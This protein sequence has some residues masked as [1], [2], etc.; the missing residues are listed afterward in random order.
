MVAVLAL[1]LGAGAA[2][3]PDPVAPAKLDD[4]CLDAGCAKKALDHFGR[5][6]AQQRGGK[7]DRPLRVSFIGDSL[8]ASDSISNALREKL[9]ALV[10]AGGPGFVFAE[11]PHPFCQHHAVTRFASG[12][13]Q[14]FGV[15][16]SVPP[17]RL[18]GL[19]GSI[20]GSGVVRF[21]PVKP[22]S[23][24]DVHYLEQPSGGAF[25]IVADNTVLETVATAATAKHAAFKRVAVPATTKAIELRAKHHVRLFGATL[26]ASKGAVV[27]NLGVVNATAKGMSKYNL[28][29]HLRNQLAHRAPDLVIVML[30][31]NEAEWL[32]PVGAGMAE[33][34]QVFGELLA[35]VR[36]AN[37]DSSCLVISPLDQIDW[38][39]PNAPA[40]TSVPAMVE[41]QHRAA[42]AHG[43]AF[44]NIYEWMGGKG[45]SMTWFKRGL[46]VKDFQHPT[47]QGANRI[48]DALYS[49]LV[50]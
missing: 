24:I 35:S 15:S 21:A 9:G 1:A 27:D 43:C 42:T 6:L 16:T 36:A 5:A 31:T 8:T 40:R 3:K 30:G 49:G 50:H 22:I 7:A 41:A 14:V 34:E 32:A 11:R 2:P 17:D 48:A 46:V 19:G 45:S 26:E 25:E 28:P 47:T 33:H 13:W 4:P 44:W 23:S 20:E 12:S 38:R 37:A 10:G 39:L 29:D 18:L